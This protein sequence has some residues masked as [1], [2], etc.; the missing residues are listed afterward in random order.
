MIIP[1]LYSGLTGD[2]EIPMIDFVPTVQFS[3]ANLL[4]RDPL[5]GFYDSVT[6]V[7][8]PKMMNAALGIDTSRRVINCKNDLKTKVG[9]PAKEKSIVR[10]VTKGVG[11]NTSSVFRQPAN[12]PVIVPT[13]SQDA[14]KL[15]M[16]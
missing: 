14:S 6:D 4:S 8:K 16:F 11:R 9:R 12:L 2:S 7:Y 13:H 1:S 5:L 15:S 3:R 10:P